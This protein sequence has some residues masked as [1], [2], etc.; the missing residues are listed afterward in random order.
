MYIVPLKISWHYSVRT[1]APENENLE[2]ELTNLFIKSEE[3]KTQFIW[4]L[5]HN[6][7][8][9]KYKAVPFSVLE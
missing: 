3:K 7:I 6:I 5:F 9:K 8:F 2:G 4:L 1:Q